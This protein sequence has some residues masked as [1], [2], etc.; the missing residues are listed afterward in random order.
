MWAMIGA[1]KELHKSELETPQNKETGEKEIWNLSWKYV[2]EN[3]IWKYVE[4]S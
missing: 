3:N 2:N 1:A 4:Y